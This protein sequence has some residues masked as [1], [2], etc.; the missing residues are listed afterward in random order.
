MKKGKWTFLYV[1]IT[2]LDG[3]NQGDEVIRMVDTLPVMHFWAFQHVSKLS[4][5][6]IKKS[7]R[8]S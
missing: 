1:V 2:A 7:M 8:L 5:D 4:M 3:Q 6:W